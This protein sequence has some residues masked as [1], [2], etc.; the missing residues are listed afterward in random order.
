MMGHLWGPASNEDLMPGWRSEMVRCELEKDP[1]DSLTG[2]G[3]GGSQ[4]YGENPSWP[5]LGW[6]TRLVRQQKPEDGFRGPVGF[7]WQPEVC[8]GAGMCPG[9]W[10]GKRS[11][12]VPRPPWGPQFPHL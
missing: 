1:L 6:P 11:G 12:Q 3:L 7:W 10:E 5:G 8:H 4:G 9:E 2:A